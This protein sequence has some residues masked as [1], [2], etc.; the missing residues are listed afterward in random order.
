[1][2]KPKLSVLT[3][4]YNTNPVHLREMIESVLGQTFRD[5]EFLILNDSPDNKELKTIVESYNDP[6]IKYFENKKNIGIANSYNRMI[7]VARGEYFAICEHDDISVPE[8]FEKQVAFLDKN[9]IVGVV[10]GQYRYFDGKEKYTS[11]HPENNRDIKYMLLR[12]GCY[13][14]H[15]TAMIRR[16][17]MN[18]VRYEERF[19]PSMD[20]MLWCRL[21]E[22]TAFHNLQEVL[23]NYRF[24]D[25]MTSIIQKKEMSLATSEI[26]LWVQNRYPAWMTSEGGGGNKKLS[27]FG[28]IPLLSIKSCKNKTNKRWVKLFGII[29]VIKIKG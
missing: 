22:H 16:S 9:R 4:L 1:M 29:P 25:N 23:I 3:P 18:G 6:R 26:L 27:L 20:Y 5:F 2:K 15:M 8:R 19:S 12:G 13:I 21:M 7:D 28:F 11:A 17:A 24:H 10:S 14:A